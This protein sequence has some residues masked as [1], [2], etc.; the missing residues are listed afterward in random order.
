MR[1]AHLL[2][3]IHHL[4]LLRAWWITPSANPPCTFLAFGVSL[5]M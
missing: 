4:L 5:P 2:G 1:E 3:V